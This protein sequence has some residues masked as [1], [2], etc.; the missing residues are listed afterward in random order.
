MASSS[1]TSELDVTF[2]LPLFMVNRSVHDP[3]RLSLRF[4][5]F[6]EEHRAGDGTLWVG[7]DCALQAGKF[8]YLLRLEIFRSPQ[9]SGSACESAPLPRASTPRAEV[10][11]EHC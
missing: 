4:F 2:L 1:E 7:F 9:S 8:F 3:T 11:R 10:V 5:G 6:L